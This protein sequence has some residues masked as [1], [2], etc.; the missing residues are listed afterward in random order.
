MSFDEISVWLEENGI[1]AD[2]SCHNGFWIVLIV[3]PGTVARGES[4][5]LEKAFES[6]IKRWEELT[7][8]KK[9]EEKSLKEILEWLEENGL[10]AV[11]DNSEGLWTVKIGVSNGCVMGLSPILTQAFECAMEQ[12]RKEPENRLE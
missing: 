10:K 8:A 12:W 6:A 9:N 3:R 1:G 4:L 2:V 5:I 7:A 11:I